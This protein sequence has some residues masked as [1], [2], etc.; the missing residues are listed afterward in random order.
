MA[1]IDLDS[2]TEVGAALSGEM[3][4]APRGTQ[5]GRMPNFDSDVSSNFTSVSN[6]EENELGKAIAFSSS[7][8]MEDSRRT[9][10][11]VV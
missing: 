9:G 10:E 11:T 1:L 8:Q 3:H 5:R 7:L 2:D 6:Q 4:L